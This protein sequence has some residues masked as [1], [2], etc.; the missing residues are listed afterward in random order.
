MDLRILYSIILTFIPGAELRIGLPLAMI[1]ARNHD[2]PLTLVFLL[3]VLVNIFLIFLIFF[4]LDHFHK[5]LLRFR[6]Y[7]RFFKSTV[8]RFQKRIDK[9]ERKYSTL[10]FFALTLFVAVPL[11]V[12]GA[13]SGSLIS[14]LL[15]LDRKKSIFSIAL[16]V[17]LAGLFIFLGMLG[18]LSFLF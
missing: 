12:S 10:G 13:W 17:F 16:G 1:Y 11:P 4:F 18:F 7:Q 5:W 14:W 15:G 8:K 9:F 6:F 2:I 3:I